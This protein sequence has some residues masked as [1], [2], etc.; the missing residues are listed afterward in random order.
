MHAKSSPDSGPLPACPCE[1][2]P[3]PIV[4]SDALADGAP[5]HSRLPCQ[6]LPC[7]VSVGQAGPCFGSRRLEP[8]L[9]SYP[10]SSELLSKCLQ[11][12]AT[13]QGLCQ[14]P[15]PKTN[16]S[17][18]CPE[19]ARSLGGRD[20]CEGPGQPLPTQPCLRGCG[21]PEGGGRGGQGSQEEGRKKGGEGTG[22][23][24]CSWGQL[25]APMVAPQSRAWV[26]VGTRT[27]P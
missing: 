24:M 19:G 9:T 20:L 17:H 16:E 25:R 4:P 12:P 23:S 6:G 21:N 8:W 27:S 15:A 18:P 11:N 1:P 22:D 14:A 13:C 10:R 7:A 26:C 5:G 3:Q 2:Q